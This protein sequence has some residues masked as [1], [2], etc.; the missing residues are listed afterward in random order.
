MGPAG[1][2]RG[3]QT[4]S[5]AWESSRRGSKRRLPQA[6]PVRAGLLQPWVSH[7]QSQRQQCPAEA[8]QTGGGASCGKRAGVLEAEGALQGSAEVGV[9]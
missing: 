2:S 9:P 8:G 5:W 4:S 7:H 1:C 3:V 6:G